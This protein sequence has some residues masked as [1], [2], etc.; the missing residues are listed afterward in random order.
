MDTNYIVAYNH[1]WDVL[2]T[3][4]LKRVAKIRNV[5]YDEKK[6]QFKLKF[7]DNDYILDCNKRTIVREKDG[8]V[9]SAETN[10]IILNYL[11]YTDID[12][13]KS[14]QWVSLKEVPNGGM[15]FYPAFH[16]NT[17]IRLID[18]YGYDLDSFEKICLELG[19]VPCKLGD[20]GFEFEVF[21]KIS[22]KIG[23]WEGDDE[24]SPSVNMLFNKYV[25]NFMHVESVIGMGM[26]IGKQIF[27]NNI[28][29]LL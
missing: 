7:L 19:G 23:I 21:P 9:H 18:K 29:G 10:V 17:I 15:L 4:D 14:S 16:K 8:Y 2:D 5:I 25:E 28:K 13:E 20:K 6:N 24:I 12:A 11:G 22:I 27:N 1:E 26:Y 3:R